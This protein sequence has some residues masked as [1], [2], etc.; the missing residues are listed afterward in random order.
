MNIHRFKMSQLT[1]GYPKELEYKLTENEIEDMLRTRLSRAVD[2]F[3]QKAHEIVEDVTEG[4]TLSQQM[5][6]HLERELHTGLT[7][8]YNTVK[9]K[10]FV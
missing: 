7:D 2:K 4:K 9:Q 3:L 6:V 1:D 8:L 10:E 5:I